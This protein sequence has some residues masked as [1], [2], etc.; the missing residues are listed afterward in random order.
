MFDLTLDLSKRNTVAG[1]W[2][3]AMFVYL[4]FYSTSQISVQRYVSMPSVAAARRS[5][6]TAGLV[7]LGVCLLFFLLGTSIF[8]FYQQSASLSAPAG[9]GFPALDKKD[10]LLPYFVQTELPYSG[11]TGL[12]LAGLM[13]AG[14]SSVDG[15]IN[16]LTACVICDWFCG[17]R[18]SVRVSRAMSALFGAGVIAS[19]LIVPMFGETVFDIILKIAGTCFG[20]LLGL[21]TL[22][23]FV[24]RANATGAIVGLFAGLSS[25]ALV[26]GLTNVTHLWYGAV[27]CVPTV[28]VGA[29]ASACLP[30]PP[31]EKV[32]GLTVWSGRNER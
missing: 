20:P 1:S 19:A 26:I 11:F 27:T 21:F 22:G 12:F 4:S 23:V 8:A 9:G 5:L 25:I 2:A 10:Q 3:Y 15:G 29:L 28:L 32:V 24:P 31:A 16:C 7:N 6:A 17:Q 30:R 14:F 13:A 18:L